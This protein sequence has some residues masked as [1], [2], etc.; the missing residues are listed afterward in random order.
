MTTTKKPR[1]ADLKLDKDEPS[2]LFAM[3]QMLSTGGVDF[4]EWWEN[5]EEGYDNR[6]DKKSNFKIKE[7]RKIGERPVYTEITPASKNGGI[8]SIEYTPNKKNPKISFM[9]SGTDAQIINQIVQIEHFQ[10]AAGVDSLSAKNAKPPLKGFPLIKLT[11]YQSYDDTKK[12]VDGTQKSPTR[13]IKY[14][15]MPGF[16]DDQAVVDFGLAQL[17][18]PVDVS[19]WA[20]GI[21]NTFVL[22]GLYRW[23]KGENVI[24]YTGMIARL[25]GIEGWAYCTNENEGEKLFTAMLIAVGK[26]VDPLGFNFSGS[27]EPAKKFSPTKPTKKVLGQEWNADEL[28]PTDTVIFN[29][30]DLWLPKVGTNIP[31][32]QGTALMYKN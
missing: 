6:D 17:V 18:K 23:D 8:R 11:F 16:T 27:T 2:L 20:K 32:V 19:K 15:R 31:L 25:Q 1:V 3:Q 28:R 9:C 10:I 26:K 22:P 7:W 21:L 24:S 12:R 14:I 29:R 4:K 5:W 30:A 13:G